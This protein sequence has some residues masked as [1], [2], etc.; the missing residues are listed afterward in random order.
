MHSKL[1][2]DKR[3]AVYFYND[4]HFSFFASTSILEIVILEVRENQWKDGPYDLRL[5]IE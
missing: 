1:S 4:F 3:L 2:R 5:T